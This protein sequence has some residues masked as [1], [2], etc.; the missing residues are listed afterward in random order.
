M[1]ARQLWLS[2]IYS[3]PCSSSPQR[4]EGD[5]LDHEAVKQ[6]TQLLKDVGVEVDELITNTKV[7]LTY[8]SACCKV[9]RYQNSLEG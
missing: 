1:L 4:L 7:E 8:I 3:S 2:E 5:L 9:C 6:C